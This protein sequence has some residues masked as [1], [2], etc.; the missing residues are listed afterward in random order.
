MKETM[1]MK[2]HK[3][4]SQQTGFHGRCN[5]AV[6]EGKILGFLGFDKIGNKISRILGFLVFNK[7][8]NKI[9]P[10]GQIGNVEKLQ[11]AVLDGYGWFLKDQ[12]S[13]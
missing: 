5:Q 8:G 2:K 11:Q 10:P 13:R 7:I 12:S 9:S 6:V 1:M 4:L 3:F